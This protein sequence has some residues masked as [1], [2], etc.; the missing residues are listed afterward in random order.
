MADVNCVH[1]GILL[2][3]F[4]PCSTKVNLG[5]VCVYLP[6]PTRVPFFPCS[7]VAWRQLKRRGV[8]R[9]ESDAAADRDAGWLLDTA[10]QDPRKHSVVRLPDLA[11]AY[12]V[13]DGIREEVEHGQE[14]DAVHL[15]VEGHVRDGV[16]VNVSSDKRVGHE[17]QPEYD[18][19]AHEQES[20]DE[21]L[22]AVFRLVASAGAAQC[23]RASPVSHYFSVN[24]AVQADDDEDQ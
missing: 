10:G 19:G 15:D 9:R 16:D 2:G 18:Q 4:V 11:H 24:Q 17:R 20:G 21:G 7:G 8:E 22:V 1:G 23:R 5:S 3:F 14:V 13:D 12:P 6:W